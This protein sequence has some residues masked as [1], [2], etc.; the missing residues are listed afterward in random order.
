MTVH[1]ALGP[2]FLE[3]VYQ[4]SLAHELRKAGLRLDCHK[5]INVYYDN[6]VVGEFEADMLVEEKVLLELKAVQSLIPAHEVQLVMVHDNAG[7]SGRLMP[8][9]CK[10]DIPGP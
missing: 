2:G 10:N 9:G 6:V 1:S 5:P 8:D 3:S 4:N 7:V